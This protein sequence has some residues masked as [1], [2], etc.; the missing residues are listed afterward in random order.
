MTETN[1]QLRPAPPLASSTAQWPQPVLH[2]PGPVPS[3]IEV[4][5]YSVQDQVGTGASVQVAFEY[6]KVALLDIGTS[7]SVTTS[8][9]VK[10][11]PV[12]APKSA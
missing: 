5:S 9:T 8:T 4:T 7:T 6:A 2:C 12:T 1:Y 10:P 11:R 3:G